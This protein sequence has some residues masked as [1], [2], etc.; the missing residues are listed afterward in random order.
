M[1]KNPLFLPKSGFFYGSMGHQSMNGTWNLK[2]FISIS[3][4]LHLFVFSLFSILMP[5]LKI[6]QLPRLNIEV[7]LLPLAREER[8]LLKR[9]ENR[10]K[11]QSWE[12]G[13]RNQEAEIK[14]EAPTPMKIHEEKEMAQTEKVE[15]TL[16]KK[17][18]KTAAA[19]PVQTEA[20]IIPVSEPKPS[21]LQSEKKVIENKQEE[22][23]VIAS[24]GKDRK[25]VV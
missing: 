19:L 15:I 14:T 5:D 22:R 3:L 17:E 7:S 20:K 12:L 18:E 2:L 4:G 24:L 9:V 11:V 23:V 25:S 8:E 16:P 6:T 21:P 1:L 10:E 13:V